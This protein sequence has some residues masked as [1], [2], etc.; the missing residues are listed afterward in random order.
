MEKFQFTPSIRGFDFLDN[1]FTVLANSPL[2]GFMLNETEGI[3]IQIL[4]VDKNFMLMNYCDN[5]NLVSYMLGR[6]RSSDE[7]KKSYEVS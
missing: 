6:D 1:N 2:R 3:Q 5:S 4:K 7:R